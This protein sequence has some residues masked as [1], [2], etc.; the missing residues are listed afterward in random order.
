MIFVATSS[1]AA[2]PQVQNMT[3]R[4]TPRPDSS[5]PSR[6]LAEV[7]EPR[8]WVHHVADAATGKLLT[9]PLDRP[10]APLSRAER[11]SRLGHQFNPVIFGRPT[12]RL[13]PRRPYQ[14]SPQ[15]FLDFQFTSLVSSYV[16]DPNG[17]ADWLLEY[18]DPGRTG[19]MDA[20][21][22][23]AP[24]GRCLLTLVLGA[25]A[26]TGQI[27]HIRIEVRGQPTENAPLI[28]AFD[29]PAQG[30]DFTEHT[31]DLLFGSAPTVPPT[32][33]VAMI[34]EPGSGLYF[35]RFGSL[36][37]GLADLVLGL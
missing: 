3:T 25:S 24:A 29:I 15:G 8:G 4:T 7:K 36:T 28:V 37:F 32:R 12:H 1:A 31:F 6:N 22:L 20:L 18:I 10:I 23:D 26:L 14:A 2:R 11:L 16:D 9:T 5:F 19:R 17:R 35:V 34:L 21:L 13:T 30:D 27:G 33:W